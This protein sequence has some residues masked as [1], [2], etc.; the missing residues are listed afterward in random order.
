MPEVE[1]IPGLFSTSPFPAPPSPPPAPGLSL[2]LL[3]IYSD[4]TVTRC[5]GKCILSQTVGETF[6]TNYLLQFS[7]LKW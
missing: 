1:K 6:S 7:Y 2:H 5:N 4:W 3:G